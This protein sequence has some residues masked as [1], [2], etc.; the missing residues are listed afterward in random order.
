MKILFLH[1]NFP[2]QFGLFG[3][4]LAREGWHVTYMTQRKGSKA[5]GIDAIVYRDREQPSEH[6][7]GHPFLKAAGKAVVTG[8]SALEVALHLR[9]T[10]DYVPDVV[11]SHSGWG[12]GLFLRDV[13]PEAKHVSYFEWYYKGEADD[14]VFLSGA[15]RPAMEKARERMRNTPILHDLVSCDLGIVPTHYQAR[16]FPEIFRSKMAV[17]HDGIDTATFIPAEAPDTVA[18]AGETY[19]PQDE[20]V[21]Y[22]A[23]GMEPYRGFPEFMEVLSLVQSRRPT[24][25]AIV[26]GEDRSAYG[27]S[28]ASGNTYKED[29]LERLPLDRNRIH[30]TGLL[31]RNEYL[32]VLQISSVHCYF[33]VPF[34]L[35]WSAMEAMSAGCLILGSDTDPLKEIATHRKNAWL[36]D[37]R[38][39]QRTA[40]EL[41]YLLATRR[42]HAGLREAARRTI[43]ERFAAKDLFPAKKTLLSTLVNEGAIACGC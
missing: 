8:T 39:I 40:D 5:A 25:R 11:V 2:A 15:G 29:A 34:V 32:R 4:Y 16:Q 10:R 21:T 3:Q 36:T 6:A 23:R 37:F 41:E 33:T 19:T 26:V 24:L 17:M 43:V 12:P 38:D 9:H 1:N 14:V 42:E 30:F 18:I 35:S 13:W 31:P 22:V 7:V 20:I 27:R 28:L